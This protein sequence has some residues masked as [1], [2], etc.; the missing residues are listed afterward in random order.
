[1]ED[2]SILEII[3]S[4]FL[5]IFFVGFTIAG[6]WVATLESQERKRQ[7]RNGTHDYYGNKLDD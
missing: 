6:S 1:M 3:L 7:Y 5:I 4:W 2:M